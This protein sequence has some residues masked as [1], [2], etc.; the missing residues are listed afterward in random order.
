MNIFSKKKLYLITGK[1]SQKWLMLE[2]GWTKF[3]EEGEEIWVWDFCKAA[4]TRPRI[5]KTWW[6]ERGQSDWAEGPTCHSQ[7]KQKNSE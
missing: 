6:N 5:K 2:R 1:T 4:A 7:A 3:F